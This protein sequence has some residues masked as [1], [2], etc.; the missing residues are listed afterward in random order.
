[1]IRQVAGREV[2]LDYTTIER[3]TAKQIPD[4]A[5]RIISSLNEAGVGLGDPI[6]EVGAND[7]SFLRAL[8][9]AG[10]QN[11]SGVEPSRRLAEIAAAS[12]FRVHGDYFG[13]DL[14]NRIVS[15]TGAV[16]AVICR[17]TL[18]HVPDSRSLV[19][20]IA[21]VLLPGGL[22]F[23]EVPDTDW[24]VSEL[25]VHEVWDEHINYFRWSSLAALL[26]AC[27]LTPIRME[28]VRFRDTC[29]LLSWS[30]RGGA[31]PQPALSGGDTTS[32]ADVAS[33]QGRWDAFAGR[34]RDAVRTAPKPVIAMGASH[35]QLNFLNFSGLDG[36]VD[37]LM[38]D[39]PKKT[40]C[41]A[42]LAKAVPIKTTRDI[43]DTVRT[44]TILQTA[45]PYPAWE[46]RV[47]S[48][49]EPLGVT[50]IKPYDL[51]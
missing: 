27:G 35:N 46:E 6:L 17:H 40:G 1:M 38:D 8:R 22:A 23:I 37:L 13:R 11:L 12:G 4:Y 3:D 43:L 48:A 18:E 50:F 16:K 34:L 25:F 19:E 31:A 28:R 39:D 9:D 2:V 10:F 26:G 36:S 44:G 21:K 7:G 30:V 51:K 42:P 33:L 14:A 29:N 15:D 41:F 49:L 32:L 45:F 20:G 5:A 24:I 47:R